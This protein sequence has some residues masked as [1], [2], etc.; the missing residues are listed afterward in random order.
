MPGPDP[1]PF[2][3]LE[4]YLYHDSHT[5]IRLNNVMLVA[6]T[7]NVFVI[8]VRIYRPRCKGLKRTTLSLLLSQMN[9]RFHLCRTKAE[10]VATKHE[11]SIS[12]R[13][14]LDPSSHLVILLNSSCSS[15]ESDAT[16]CTSKGLWRQK[17]HGVPRP[18]RPRRKIS[19]LQSEPIGSTKP[20]LGSQNQKR[21]TEMNVAPTLPVQIRCCQSCPT[22]QCDMSNTRQ[23][24]SMDAKRGAKALL[25]THHLLFHVVC[26]LSREGLGRGWLRLSVI[27]SIPQNG[28][29]AVGIV[30]RYSNMLGIHLKCIFLTQF[31]PQDPGS[32]TH[33][34]S[35]WEAPGNYWRKLG[36][37]PEDSGRLAA[38]VEA[39]GDPSKLASQQLEVLLARRLAAQLVH[40]RA[41]AGTA[42]L[43]HWRA[44]AGTAGLVHWRA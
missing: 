29:H 19:L 28:I 20:K 30:S 18:D 24:E 42:G 39:L 14:N 10:N 44:K 16:T 11:N 5:Q 32:S 36:K 3:I 23:D 34:P 41:K 7:G 35:V 4:L 9:F 31:S 8:A 22:D 25:A 6:S 2:I 26:H 40:W 13:L 1:R 17:G 15:S 21:N 38:A 12:L 43:V 33:Y 37:A 27:V